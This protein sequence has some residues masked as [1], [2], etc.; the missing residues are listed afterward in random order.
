[1]KEQCERFELNQEYKVVYSKADIYE[2]EHV[3]SDTKNRSLKF[4]DTFFVTERYGRKLRERGRERVRD[5][6]DSSNLIYSNLI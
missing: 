4:G 2:T 3:K 5:L 1:M 6:L